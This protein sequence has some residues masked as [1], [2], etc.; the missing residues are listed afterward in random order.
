MAL[1]VIIAGGGT[2]GHIFPG[3]AIAREF[4]SRDSSNEILFVGTEQGLEK[5][6][7]PREG[8]K[9]E[10]IHVAALKSVSIAKRIKSLLMLP[11]SFLE[12]R[13]LLKSFRPDV[14]I[15]VGGYS[16]GPVLLLAALQGLPTMVIE[17]NALPGFTNRVLANFIDKAAVTF[18]VSKPYFKGKAVVTGNP[19]RGEFQ[20]IAKKTRASQNHLLIFGGSQGAYA[21]NMAMIEALPK[22]EAKKAKLSITHQTGEKDLEQVRA[23]YQQHGWSA[24][25]RPFIDKIVDEFA[26]ADL[27]LCRSGATTVAELTAAGK[28][29]ILV[30][31]PLA[32]DDHQRKNAEA[33]E[34][35]GAAK[36]IVQKDLTIERLAK[37][38]VDLI[39]NQE[40]IDVMEIASRKLAHTDAAAKTVDLALALMN[41]KNK[42]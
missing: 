35:A 20:N 7:I 21:I 8:F 25:V 32:A 19:V 3:V 39:D 41:Q 5:K 34:Q 36:M 37:E 18:E 17:P 42:R 11:G 16:S 29:A 22:L 27:I 14:V 40:K 15:G 33:L 30:P 31:F 38:L 13:K 12:V 9:L 6:I 28:A 1:K 23:A 2:G 26:R 10:M 24:D 4:Q